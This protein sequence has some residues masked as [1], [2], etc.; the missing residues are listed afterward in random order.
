VPGGAVRHVC[1]FCQRRRF[2]RPAKQTC[3]DAVVLPQQ[4][5][6]VFRFSLQKFGM[7]LLNLI[8]ACHCTGVPKS[9]VINVI[10]RFFFIV[11]PCILKSKATH[12]PTDALLM[13]LGKV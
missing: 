11:A 9:P 12:L 7:F 5:A 6:S 13:T 10:E 3:T 1:F 4:M 2:L 8:S